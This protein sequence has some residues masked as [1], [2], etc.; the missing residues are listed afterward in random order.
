MP[1]VSAD[2][3]RQ[4]YR[5]AISKSQ[6]TRQRGIGRTSVRRILAALPRKKEVQCPRAGH[7]GEGDQ[8]APIKG[9]YKIHYP[10]R[11]H[12]LTATHQ[13]EVNIRPAEI[14]KVGPKS[15]QAHATHTWS[16]LSRMSQP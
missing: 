8:I 10:G 5:Y 1:C 9:S 3:I 12:G 2:N 4:L 16:T 14:L 11:Q 15:S 13:D 6:I 7:A